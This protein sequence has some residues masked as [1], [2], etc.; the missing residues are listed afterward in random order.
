MSEIDKETKQKIG[1]AIVAASEKDYVEFK[2]AIGSSVE[3]RLRDAIS[4]SAQ[5]KREKQFTKIAT[6]ETSDNTQDDE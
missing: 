2:G 1:A 3:D 6:P 4:T 5:D